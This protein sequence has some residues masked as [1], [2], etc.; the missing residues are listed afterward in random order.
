MPQQGR[1]KSGPLALTGCMATMLL[2][3]GAPKEMLWPHSEM[4]VALQGFWY[5]ASIIFHL[6]WIFAIW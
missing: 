1:W 3:L 6:G 5:H 2:V 4:I